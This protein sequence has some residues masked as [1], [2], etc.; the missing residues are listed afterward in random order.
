MA[1][2][3]LDSSV[4]LL[5]MGGEG[6]TGSGELS[7]EQVKH[8]IVS[9]NDVMESSRKR[10]HSSGSRIRR[11]E[12]LCTSQSNDQVIRRCLSK[13]RLRPITKIAD[14]EEQVRQLTEMIAEAH[15]MASRA[16][17]DGATGLE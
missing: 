16:S 4:I 11:R 9:L 10:S 13:G 3:A 12:P 8:I 7:P 14:A 1:S 17:E 5:S 6:L 15:V 2:V